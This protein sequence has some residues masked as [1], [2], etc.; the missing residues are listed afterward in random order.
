MRLRRLQQ[1]RQVGGIVREVGVHLQHQLSASSRGHGGSRDVGGA[2]TSLRGR[3]RTSTP[4]VLGGEAVG[5][6]PVT[7]PA[8]CRRR[9]QHP[10][11]T[12]AAWRTDGRDER[13]RCSG[14]VEG[15]ETSR[16]GAPAD[17]IG[18]TCSC[19]HAEIAAALDDLGPLRARRAVKYRVLAYSTAAKAIRESPVSIAELAREAG[20]PRSPGSAR[21][22]RRRSTPCSPPAR[23]PP[24]RS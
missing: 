16:R 14:L 10:R 2:E 17:A 9:Y 20:R 3:C 13:P 8:S 4:V 7:V 22:W 15:G 23:S 12:A 18:L 24:P 11:V 1:A 6:P 19:D 5:D 21:R